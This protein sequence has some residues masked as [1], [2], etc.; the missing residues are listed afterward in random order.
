MHSRLTHWRVPDTL[1]HPR[2]LR[3]PTVPA[4]QQRVHIAVTAA[5]LSDAPLRCVSCDTQ[6]HRQHSE[7]PHLHIGQVVHARKQQRSVTALSLLCESALSSR[8]SKS[9]TTGT[10]RQR[11]SATETTAWRSTAAARRSRTPLSRAPI[12]V[13][14]TVWMS[15]ATH[16]GAHRP[17]RRAERQRETSGTARTAA[18]WRS[19]CKCARTSTRPPSNTRHAARRSL[20]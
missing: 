19:P 8:R 6:V 15:P 1:T 12:T 14:L 3:P 7:Q 5:A 20:A 17:G 10:S 9:C 16:T 4:S 13:S 2:R 18:L 11:A